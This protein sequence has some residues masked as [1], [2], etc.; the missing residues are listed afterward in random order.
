MLAA[1]RKKTSVVRLLLGAGA[2]ADLLDTSSR[3]ALNYAERA[4]C[5]EC[6]ELLREAMHLES[7]RTQRKNISLRSI[8]AQDSPE[9]TGATPP[10]SNHSVACAVLDRDTSSASIPTKFISPPSPVTALVEIDIDG[11]PGSIQVDKPLHKEMAHEMYSGSLAGDTAED[12]LTEHEDWE[13][14]VEAIAPE[15]NARIAVETRSLHQSLSAHKALDADETWN[16]IALYLPDKAV[17]LTKESET[18]RISSLLIRAI[19]D[20]AVSLTCLN[21]AC[22][23][24]DETIDEDLKRVLIYVIGDIG[25]YIEQ[26]LQVA[27]E[28]NRGPP[29]YDTERQVADALAW[30]DDL[31]SGWNSPLRFY[32]KEFKES[33][34][35]AEEEI[36]LSKE[37]EES[38]SAA[39][40]SLSHWPAG[41]AIVYA[42]AKKVAAGEEDVE[43]YSSGAEPSENDG[44]MVLDEGMIDDEL[45][46]KLNS[47][48]AAF[49]EA[50]NQARSFEGSDIMRLR[51][52]LSNVGFSRGFLLD[53]AKNAADNLYGLSFA[54]SISRQTAARERM[55]A[56]NLRLAYSI[57]KKYQWST[58]A[59][60]DLVQEANIGLMKAVDRFDWKKGFRFS[61]YSSWWIRQQVGRSISDNG[62]AVRVPV[63]VHDAV[64]KIMRIREE[65]ENQEQRS[66]SEAEL[67]ART[68][69]SVPKLSAMLSALQPLDSLDELVSICSIPKVETLADS[70]AKD[71]LHALEGEQLS[72]VLLAYL[73]DLDERSSQVLRLRFGLGTEDPMTLEEV[74][75]RFNVTR[76]RIRQI[77]AKALRKL[78]TAT[79]AAVLAPF[80]NESYAPATPT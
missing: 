79:K 66:V 6:T 43:I 39:L 25:A 75:F 9:E 70:Q 58:E 8:I 71:P 78:S 38:C 48:A 16:D 37:I 19:S 28:P 52:A 21:E 57:A 41:L 51:T 34:L 4:G 26:N 33:L 32:L 30:V 59:I 69:Y 60:E 45:E 68:E 10:D 12:T 67:A 74:G 17:P 20:G 7:S 18:N 40:D 44:A 35:T 65:Y 1:G 24:S 15:G 36:S 13:P 27:E 22:L 11:P 80:I 77:E 63:H 56:A 14:E 50:V 23:R 46:V 42:A 47:D 5:R 64:R 73:A 72:S 61:T 29:S 54:S 31:V 62:R 2:N 53:L 3:S 76:E 49:V 55:I